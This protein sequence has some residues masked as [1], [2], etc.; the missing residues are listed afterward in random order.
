MNAVGIYLSLTGLELAMHNALYEHHNAPVITDPE[1]D[2][3]NTKY[4]KLC[5][6]FNLSPAR[7]L[8]RDSGM[9]DD[10][11]LKSH[12]YSLTRSQ[13][14]ARIKDIQ[15]KRSDLERRLDIKYLGDN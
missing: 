8:S 12:V 4:F 3:L 13:L 9:M 10:G 14:C 11:G 1:Y 7:G 6:K 2:Q 5:D 15:L